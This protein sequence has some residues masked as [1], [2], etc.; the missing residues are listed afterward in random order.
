MLSAFS[1]GDWRVDPSLHSI[2]GA[3]GE[4]RL[5]PQGL[6]SP[7]R[8]GPS[9]DSNETKRA[10]V[11]R[12]TMQTTRHR[13]ASCCVLLVGLPLAPAFGQTLV[14]ERPSAG[15]QPGQAATTCQESGRS[16]V[17]RA[18]RLS[19]EAED[20]SLIALLGAIACR[21]P[22]AISAAPEIEADRISIVFAALPVDEG[23]RRILRT[24]DAFFYYAGGP[25]SP[26]LAGLWVFPQGEGRGLAP[27]NTMAWASDADI[28]ARLTAA[29]PDARARAL[30][31]LVARRGA[32]AMNAVLA[33]LADDDD[34]V[35]VRAM[36]LA[37]VEGLELPADRV[38]DLAV[39]DRSPVV[40][41]QALQIAA[42]RPEL[43]SVAE[44]AQHDPDPAVRSE[45]LATLA[46]HGAA[47][48]T[49]PGA[50]PL[51]RP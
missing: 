40:R 30:A 46:R 43:A 28:E 49:S 33:A 36:E 5:E 39:N 25:T 13:L 47:A 16:V 1:I 24:Y 14:A 27:L 2:T 19:V 35:R 9:I 6:A 8:S 37:L 26:V 21:T 12:Q 51:R 45:A 42:E 4:I 23:L 38:F 29:D 18:G 41:L 20:Q 32:S 3:P 44:S 34:Q 17:V 50:K 10:E 15:S 11:E 7:C 48:P 31:A 22:L